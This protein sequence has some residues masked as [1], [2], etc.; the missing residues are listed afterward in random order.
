VEVK[1]EQFAL[2]KKAPVISYGEAADHILVTCRRAPDASSND[3]V[4]VLVSKQDY[5]LDPISTWDTLGFRGTCSA[6]FQLTAA[7]SAD[8]IIPVPFEDILS[9]T[10]HPLSHRMGVALSVSPPMPLI[11][12]VHSSGGGAEES[13]HRSN[14]GAP[15][16]RSRQP[17]A[18]DAQHHQG[19]GERVCPDAAN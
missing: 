4:H 8:Q 13:R 1:G 19:G 2:V 10:M 7:G 18:G 14:I 3:Q 16:C 5:R 11:R 17:A 9:Q 15:P 6:G 12:R